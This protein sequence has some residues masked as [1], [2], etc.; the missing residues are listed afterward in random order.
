MQEQLTIQLTQT[1]P[2]TNDDI[3]WLLEHIGHPNPD[4]RD[5]LVY[6]SFCHM[7][8]DELI[9]PEQLLHLTKV[10]KEKELLYRHIGE[11]DKDTLTRSFTALLYALILYVDNLPESLYFDCLPQND[12]EA[13]F[14]MALDYL[15]VETDYRGYDDNLG[16][17][18]A[19]A[20]GSDFLLSAISHDHFPTN[21]YDDILTLLITF[22]EKQETVFTAGEDKRLA[23]VLSHLLIT[24]KISAEQVIQNLLKTNLHDETPKAYFAK[25]NLEQFLSAL[26]F[27]LKAENYHNQD[28][29]IAIEKRLAQTL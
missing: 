7:L 14:D 11:Q 20:H 25:L 5:E 21:R 26:Y 18:H 27:Q 2:Y 9:T 1:E 17:I 10:A 22:F 4:I 16:W 23:L 24:E 6:A 13:L 29:T 15:S 3:H 12:K 28:V 8:L 19:I